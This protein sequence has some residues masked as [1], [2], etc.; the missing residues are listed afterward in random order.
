MSVP[1]LLGGNAL[2]QGG[3]QVCFFT[4]PSR[5]SANNRVFKRPLSLDYQTSSFTSV[6]LL[7]ETPQISL[8]LSFTA[9]PGV[10]SW[11][12]SPPQNLTKYRNAWIT[13]VWA[14]PSSRAS[15]FS[16]G[17][18]SSLPR[19]AASGVHVDLPVLQIHFHYNG[20]KALCYAG[21]L[22]GSFTANV[23]APPSR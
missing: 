22:G 5:S 23:M 11:G 9:L 2:S 18:F 17:Q 14:P 16:D 12:L 10:V 7:W 19:T 15:D 1:H 6:F 4:C 21:F 8:T 13:G 3:F 20:I